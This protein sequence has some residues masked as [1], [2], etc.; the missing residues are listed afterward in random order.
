MKKSLN[1]K[2][3]TGSHFWTQLKFKFHSF[4]SIKK[5]QIIKSQVKNWITFLDTTQVTSKCNQQTQLITSISQY[6]H[7]VHC[8]D[9]VEAR[10]KK[11][12]KKSE[13]H[14]WLPVTAQTL[15]CPGTCLYSMGTYSDLDQLVLTS[16]RVAQALSLKGR[17]YVSSAFWTKGN[18]HFCFH[19][20]PLCGQYCVLILFVSCYQRVI[21]IC[22][23]LLNILHY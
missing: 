12:R 1:H 17:M 10:K 6:L 8:V 2:S 5:T 20:T 22:I 13:M 18:L 23:V 16:S 9:S 11:R 19:S 15:K 7:N 4:T 3:N 14:V 21:S